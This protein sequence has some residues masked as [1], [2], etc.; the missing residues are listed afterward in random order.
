M[1]PDNGAQGMKNKNHQAARIL[2]GFGVAAML[3]LGITAAT[4][5]LSPEKKTAPQQS[6][7]PRKTAKD[8]LWADLSPAQKEMLAPLEAEWD[9]REDVRKR[10][11]QIILRLETLS[12]EE[13][14]RSRERIRQWAQLT[15]AQRHEARQ[16]YLRA[17]KLNAQERAAQWQ[18][19][20][21]LPDEKKKEL[22]AQPASRKS[23]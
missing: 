7:A 9:K 16:N 22:A 8:L 18:E 17:K 5:I 23:S 19:Y 12:P 4:G 20:Q 11:R 21:N 6:A 15:P 1:E 3:I 14:E 10:W 2:M 13:K